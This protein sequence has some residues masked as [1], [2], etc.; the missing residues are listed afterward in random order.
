MT[1]P[2]IEAS[3][4][5]GEVWRVGYAP[6]PWAWASWDYASDDGLFTGRW[7]DERAAYRSIYTSE[8]LMGCFLELLAPL[9]TNE[10]TFAE[11]DAIEDD[12]EP[13]GLERPNPVF[14]TI[15]LDWLENRVYGSAQ[16]T[17]VY[18]EVTVAASL[19]ALAAAGVFSRFNIAPQHVDVSLLKD[20]RNRDLTRAVSRWL[21]DQIGPDR[22][23]LFNGVAFRSRMGDDFRMWAVFE[24]GNDSVS[25]L[26]QPA[27]SPEPVTDDIPELQQAMAVLGLSWRED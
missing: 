16:Q 27:G 6:N 23:A 11:V 10:V 25:P 18:A 3:G 4:D 13:A 9:R 26:I 17:G 24:R 1:A 21:Y 7:D 8:S 2:A 15:A 5:P 12:D 20:P 19:G 22:R 14:G